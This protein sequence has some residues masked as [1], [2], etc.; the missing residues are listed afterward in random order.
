[1]QK[2]LKKA[3]KKEKFMVK[4][5]QNLKLFEKGQVTAYNYCTQKAATISPAN[6]ISEV[7]N[8][9]FWQIEHFDV[10]GTGWMG[11]QRRVILT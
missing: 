10:K 1:M 2:I 9:D 3:K 11:L 4:N 8:I 6:F 5:V 7:I